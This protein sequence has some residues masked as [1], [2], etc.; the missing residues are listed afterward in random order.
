MY[1]CAL[2]KSQNKKQLFLQAALSDWFL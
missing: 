2:Y 1:F